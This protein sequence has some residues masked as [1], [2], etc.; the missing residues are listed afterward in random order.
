MG[1][2]GKTIGAMAICATI[3]AISYPTLMRARAPAERTVAPRAHC[4]GPLTGRT[5]TLPATT[6]GFGGLQYQAPLPLKRGEYLLTIDDGPNPGTTQELLGILDTNCIRATFFMV[7]KRAEAYAELARMIVAE[8]HGVGSHSWSHGNFSQMTPDQVKAEIDRGD[9]AVFRAA[10]GTAPGG[11]HLFRVPG[12]T[13]VPRDLP[14]AW[15]DYLKGRQLILASYDISPGDW[16]NP[17]PDTGFANMFRNFPDR[18]VIVIHD[19]P[20]NTPELLRRT[21]KELERRKATLVTLKVAGG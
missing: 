6:A 7:G 4:T 9:A 17:P 14:K 8:G 16:Q 12:A 2:P 18:G 3:A 13:G 21:L 11:A 20:S 1:V 10:F 19:W 15:T 5:V